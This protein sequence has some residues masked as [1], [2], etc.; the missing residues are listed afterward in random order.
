MSVPDRIE[1]TATRASSGVLSHRVVLRVHVE[2][3]KDLL[4]VEELDAIVAVP[5]ADAAVGVEFDA[6]APLP[7]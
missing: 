6:G 4:A 7:A 5:Q 3:G 2:M 1:T